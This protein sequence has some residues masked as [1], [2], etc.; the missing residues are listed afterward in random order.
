MVSPS[1]VQRRRSLETEV[2]TGSAKWWVLSTIGV[3]TFMSALDGSV[4]NTLLPILS[5]DLHTSVAGIEWVTT[6]Y[7]LVISGLLLSVGRAGD[8]FGHKRIYLAGFVL[9]VIG[10]ASCGMAASANMLIVLRALQ[11]L[12]AAMLMATAPAIL[13]RS[14]PPTQRGRALGALGTFTY[15]GLTA[16]PSLGGWLATSFGWR[17]VFYINVPIGVLA[18]AMAVRSVPDDRVHVREERFDFVGASLFSA[19]LVSLLIALNQGHSWGWSSLEVIG[20]LVLAAALL[21]AFIRAEL[22]RSDPMLDLTLFASRVFSGATVSALLNYAC[23]YAVLFVLPFLLIQG[24][25]LTAQQAGIV[26]TAQPIVMAVAAPLSGTFSDRIGT[27]APATIGMLLLT[28]GLALLASLVTRGS[29]TAIAAALAV[30]GLGV[31]VFVSPNN[32]ALMGAAPRHRQGIASG[33]LATSRSVGMVLGVGFAGAVFTTVV[34]H[35][36]S[37]AVG[38]SEGVRVSLLASAGVAAIGAVTSALR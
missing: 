31:G 28:I 9:F 26:L 16:G 30:I 37:P 17:S 2:L 5:R 34:A 6:V 29:L 3:G 15:L 4:V 32:S 18:L 25:G 20:L 36:A 8:L 11:A 19:G 35:A 1:L 13:T 10:S 21:M 38:L 14:F 22:R 33:V 12:G 23:V 24:R 27:R 7:L